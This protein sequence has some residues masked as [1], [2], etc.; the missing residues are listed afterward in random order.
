M[1]LGGAVRWGRLDEASTEASN[2]VDVL[3]HVP[4]TSFG[5]LPNKQPNQ[6]APIR[7]RLSPTIATSP[8]QLRPRW[9]R[10]VREK[11]SGMMVFSADTINQRAN[12]VARGRR[13]F[14][15]LRAM[16]AEG[17]ARVAG[18]TPCA[19][20]KEVRPRTPP[21]APPRTPGATRSKTVGAGGNEL[22]PRTSPREPRRTPTVRSGTLGKDTWPGTPPRAALRTLGTDHMGRDTKPAARSLF[23]F[24]SACEASMELQT[25]GRGCTVSRQIGHVG[26]VASQL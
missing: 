26:F 6:S 18:E 12:D 13:A 20:G 19:G 22:R 17:D 11:M 15:L 2:D 21:R 10:M 25:R 14:A 1:D 8:V 9:M 4:F 3:Y 24:A 7:R 5:A 23:W 16:P